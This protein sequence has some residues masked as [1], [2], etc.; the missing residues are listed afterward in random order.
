RAADLHGREVL[1]IARAE[2]HE[3]RFRE[4]QRFEVAL[5]EIL[6][7]GRSPIRHNRVRREDATSVKHLFTDAQLAMRVGADERDAWIGIECELHAGTIPARGRSRH[8]HYGSV[9]HERGRSRVHTRRT[10][11]RAGPPR[12]LWKRA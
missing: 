1:P 8:R 11:A 10:A 4:E 12:A 9:P 5:F 6:D 2:Q 7:L 3:L